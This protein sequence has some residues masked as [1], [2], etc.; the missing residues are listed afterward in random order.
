LTFFG[1][2]GEYIDTIGSLRGTLNTF[3]TISTFHNISY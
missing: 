2:L 3:P 1:S